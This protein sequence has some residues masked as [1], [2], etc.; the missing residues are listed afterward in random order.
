[1]VLVAGATWGGAIDE[2]AL[3]R[4]L[5]RPVAKLKLTSS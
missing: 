4:I 3:L 1:V 5:T 2:T